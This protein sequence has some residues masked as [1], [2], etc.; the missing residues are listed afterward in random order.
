MSKISNLDIKIRNGDPLTEAEREVMLANRE[1][2]IHSVL[3]AI[4]RK[5]PQTS[6]ED[7][8]PRKPYK[9]LQAKIDQAYCDRLGANK[10][11][12]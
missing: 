5:R 4:A 3:E 8:A 9:V 1:E 7:D 10:R 11:P 12:F 6:A 2:T